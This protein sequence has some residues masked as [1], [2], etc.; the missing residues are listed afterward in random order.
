MAKKVHELHAGVF[1]ALAHPLRL[2]VIEILQKE[3]LCFTDILEQTGGLKS[4]LSQHLTIMVSN[5]L[6]KSRRDSRC[7]YY[8]LSS[9]KVARA[10]TLMREVLTDNVLRRSKILTTR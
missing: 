7:H 10:C 4:N 5:G 2:E 9:A 6:L 8:S 3:E 1:K